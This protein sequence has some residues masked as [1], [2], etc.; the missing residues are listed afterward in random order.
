MNYNDEINEITKRL[1]S[2]GVFLTAGN[3]KP[4]TMTI[5]WGFAGAMWGKTI[6]IIPV[7][8]VRY[9]YNLIVL[10]KEF[11]VS[12]PLD[13]S[14]NKQLGYFGM[15]SGKDTD[16][17]KEQGIIPIKCRNIDT[18]AIPGN[19]YQ[20]EC[21]LIYKNEIL[22]ENLDTFTKNKWYED[23]SYHTMFYGEIIN[24]YKTSAG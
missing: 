21:R 12:V 15:V 16:K 11:S 10:N 20:L 8:P 5:S 9:T 19:C 2:T 13:D 7:R 23:G 1:N 22:K 18:Y 14:L 6:I 3:E 4:N 24:A 17:Y